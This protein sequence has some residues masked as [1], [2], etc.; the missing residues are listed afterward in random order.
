M[1]SHPGYLEALWN[2]LLS[3]EPERIR[4]TFYSLDPPSQGFVLDHLQRMLTESDWQPE[5]RL[6]AGAALQALE[7]R[8]DQED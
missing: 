4:K 2:D 5:Q 8:S 7:K 3:R 6:S 1:D